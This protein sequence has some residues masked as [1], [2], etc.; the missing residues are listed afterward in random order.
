M[1]SLQCEWSNLTR[2]INM[3]AEQFG[4]RCEVVLHDLTKDYNHTIVSIVNGH[5]TNRVQ[6]G[7]GSNLGL[8]VLAGHK[9]DGDVYN[10][11]TRTKE[12]KTLRSSTFYLRDD[13]DQVIGC[14]CINYDISDL[15]VLQ[16]ALDDVTMYPS[17][18]QDVEPEVFAKNVGE[19]LDHLIEQCTE[20]IGK[21]GFEMSKEEKIDALAFFDSKGAFLISKAGEHLREYF[22]ISKYTLYNYLEISRS[23]TTESGEKTI[24]SRKYNN[25]GRYAKGR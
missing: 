20:Y 14:I 2:L 10:Y 5:V 17:A 12:N 3:I 25:G 23:R 6:G 19:I 22:N 24:T 15:L 1:K 4:P 7:S 8:P 13:N 9:I 16:S 21:P 11:V 18:K